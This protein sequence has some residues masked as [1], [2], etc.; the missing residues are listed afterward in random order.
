[1]IDWTSG[2]SCEFSVQEVNPE[3]WAVAGELVDVVQATVTRSC[4]ESVPMLEQASVE[5]DS[6]ISPGWYRLSMLV[7]QNSVERVALGTFYFEKVDRT[8]DYGRVTVTAKG[9]SVLYPAACET[10]VV[11]DYAPAGVDGA[12]YA[13]SLLADSIPAPVEVM[14]S[15]TLGDDIVFEPGLTKLAAAWKV[16]DAGGF[17][18]QVSGD[19]TVHVSVRP[20]SPSLVLDRPG[21]AV[22]LPNIKGG[23]DMSNIPN[24]YYATDGVSLAVAVNDDPESQVSHATRGIWVD[25]YDDKP[26]RVNGETLA[27]YAGRMLAECATVMEKVTYTREYW[28][29]VQPFSMVRCGI[30]DMGLDGDAFVLSQSLSVR[31][32]VTVQ[33]TIGFEVVL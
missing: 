12:E 1:M 22:L 20:E 31:Y 10:F 21:A 17:V 27:A 3:T 15:F 2:Y 29:G 26:K 9:R 18:M 33:E 32:G 5:V 19:G 4:T 7:R 13:G 28:P 25:V 6:E 24:R 16:L 14:G 30:P 23:V 8:N 11:G